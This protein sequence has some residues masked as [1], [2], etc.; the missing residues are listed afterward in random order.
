MLIEQPTL[1]LVAST[2]NPKYICLFAFISIDLF[3]D[4]GVSSML[5]S[6]MWP[7]HKRGL[8]NAKNSRMNLVVDATMKPNCTLLFVLM[9]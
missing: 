1:V 7:F 9:L 6:K 3:L 8:N 2:L 4:R 5:Y